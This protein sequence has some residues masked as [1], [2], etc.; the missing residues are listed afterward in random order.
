[1][2][3]QPTRFEAP[4]LK[5]FKAAIFKNHVF[6]QVNSKIKKKIRRNQEKI[7]TAI[8]KMYTLFAIK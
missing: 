8:E 6:N 1:M 3:I 2:I 4:I 5:Y 7:K